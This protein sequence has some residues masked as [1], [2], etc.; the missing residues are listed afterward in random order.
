MNSKKT[1]I[2]ELNKE[3][4]VIKIEFNKEMEILKK[5]NWNTGNKKF[6]K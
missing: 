5:P 6:N 2:T 4:Y 1:Q 3:M